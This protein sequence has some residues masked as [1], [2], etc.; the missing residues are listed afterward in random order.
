LFCKIIKKKKKK[1]KTISC[2]V[3]VGVFVSRWLKT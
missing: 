2:R 1:K 3:A